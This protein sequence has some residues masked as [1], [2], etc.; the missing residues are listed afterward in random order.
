MSKKEKLI[1]FVLA[2]A[3]FTHIVDFMIMMPLGPQL[4]RIFNISPQQFSYLVASYTFSAGIFGFLGAFVID[5]FDRKT[6]FTIAYIGFTLGNISMWIS[7]KLPF[8]IGST[9]PG[10]SFW[11]YS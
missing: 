10:W 5:R 11:R 4:M 8:F 6:A 3:Q 9:N 1:L 7:A 2:A